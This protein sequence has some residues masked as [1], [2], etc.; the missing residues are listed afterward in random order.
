MQEHNDEIAITT[1]KIVFAL[2]LQAVSAI[3]S[4]V[5]PFE[6]FCSYAAFSGRVA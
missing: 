3:L 5:T 2:P 6:C 4:S 1:P